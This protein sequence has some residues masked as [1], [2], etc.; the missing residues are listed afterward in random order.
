[1]PAT[2]PVWLVVGFLG[3]GKTTLLRRLVK[4]PGGR[5][6]AFVVNEFSDV[7]VD[8]G[9]VA[10]EGGVAVSVAGGSIFCHCKVTEFVNVLGP[11]S[12]RGSCWRTAL[13][14]TGPFRTP[15]SGDARTRITSAKQSSLRTGSTCP[16]S[17]TGWR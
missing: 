10:Q 2:V 7:D 13:Q 11:K 1:M 12:V 17:S 5:K 9:L 3:A 16:C 15:S 6:L 8:A 14:A 4:S